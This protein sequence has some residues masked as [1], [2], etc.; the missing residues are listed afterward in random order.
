VAALD[1]SVA[2]RHPALSDAT[3]DAAAWAGA[4]LGHAFADPTLLTQALTHSSAG[5]PDYQR[6]EFVG[7]RVLGCAISAW[8]FAATGEE[9]GALARRLAALVDRDS[10]AAVG[11]ALGVAE[12]IR[13]DKGAMNAG[14]HR[15]DNALADVTEALIGA[16][17]IDAGWAAAD[18]FVRRAWGERLSARAAAFHDPKSRLQEWAQSRGKKLPA[19]ELIAREGPDHAP[20]FRIR[21][22]VT[23]EPPLEA[24]GASKQEA[25]M[26]AAL[27]LL[28][29]VGA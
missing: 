19:Y 7:D 23:G 2:H 1:P 21:V 4:I 24:M 13:M 25:Q 10:C 11:R 15:S 22:V 9:E 3:A 5:R 26:N 14:V 12:H 17:F 29:R 27:A 16:I 18:A 6:L 8:L 28:E 20:R